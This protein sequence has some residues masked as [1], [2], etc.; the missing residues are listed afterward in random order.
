MA[1][2]FPWRGDFQ[3]LLLAC[4][5]NHSN[6]FVYL[7]R[8][9][10]PNYFQG[11]LPTL[12]ARQLI[13]Y[14]AEQD[15]FPSWTVLRELAAR[16]T[17]SI[18][19][20]RDPES[21]I[22]LI[23]EFQKM[24]T[25]DWRFVR[26]N[27]GKYIK[28]RAVNAALVQAIAYLKEDKI[29]EG[30]LA[31]L[32]D[33][34]ARAGQNLDDLGFLFHADVDRV[35]ELITSNKYGTATGFPLLDKIWRNGWGPGWLIVPL[36][37]PKRFKTGFAINLACNIVSPQIEGDVIYYAC[38]ISQELAM[39]RAMCN[40]GGLN[41][42]YMFDSPEKFT[43]KVK[44]EMQQSVAG[45]LLF[46]SFAAKSATLL[47]IR[48]HAKMAVAQLG[49]KLKAVVIDYAETVQ[50]GGDKNDP[51]YRRSAAVYT[52][53]RALGAELGCP[54]IMP[55]RC[56]RE[57]TDKAVPNMTSFQGAFEKAGIVDVALGLCA[58]EDEHRGN[59]LRIFNFLNRHGA[60][61]QHIKGRV[62]PLSWR[63]EF[64]EEVAYE[65]EKQ[66]IEDAEEGKR[67]RRGGP[68]PGRSAVPE[69]LTGA[70]A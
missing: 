50:G 5:V 25:S 45:N 12:L 23:D 53:A 3:N 32:F 20:N 51:E 6:E 31:P 54:V 63:M 26:D 11:A 7:A 27:L 24:D 57:T 48:Q 58:T 52:G 35:V 19:G 36:A 62:D 70:G 28:E 61:G 33:E 8:E 40:I 68:K 10:K 14:Q 34:A 44:A 69:E 59:I 56:N 47:D 30:G 64:T 17:A 1:T 66:M 37:P 42:D 21:M 18:P 9:L 29:P 16:A 60:S 67:G 38:E 15:R 41:Q 22:A 39:C 2:T 46:K 55:D 49:L 65:T 4:L 13:D 43:A